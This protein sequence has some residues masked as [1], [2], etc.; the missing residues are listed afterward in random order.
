[1]VLLFAVFLSAC[2]PRYAQWGSDAVSPQL[3]ISGSY[4]LTHDGLRLPMRSW[5]PADGEDEIASVVLALHGF[6]DYSN[7]FAGVGPWLASEGHAVYAYDQRG[8]GGGPRTGYW[9]GEEAMVRDVRD[10]VGLLRSR[11][12]GKPVYLLGESMGGAVTIAAATS[13]DPP[14]IDGVV[15]S[16]PAVWARSTMPLYQ[17]AALEVVA[18]LAP[19]LAFSGK[20]LGIWP[21][22][23]VEMLRALGQ[24]PLI[25]KKSRIGTV[26]GLV[27]L[28]DQAYQRAGQIPVPVLWLY[29]KRDEIIP[30]QPTLQAA[31]HLRGEN[32]QRFVLYPNGWHMLMRDLQSETVLSDVAAWLRDPAGPL[33][34]G[35]EIDPATV[36]PDGMGREAERPPVTAGA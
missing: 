36:E 29:G 1:M 23:N 18:R 34:S 30:P 7:A 2:A 4:F 25:I 26:Y 8:F 24:D 35:Q 33:P 3:D 28:M 21:S 22:D 19:S 5:L 27:N 17:R 20:S 10:A 31:S 16:A 6:N 15:L 32:G 14:R 11:H 12:P 13:A 9:A